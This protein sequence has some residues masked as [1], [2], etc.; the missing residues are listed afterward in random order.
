MLCVAE[1]DD[2]LCSAQSSAGH[3]SKHTLHPP[4]QTA[5]QNQNTLYVCVSGQ[6]LQMKNE[7]VTWP[8]STQTWGLIACGNRLRDFYYY[9]FFN[10]QN[11]SGAATL[12]EPDG[13]QPAFQSTWMAA[14]HQKKQR[15]G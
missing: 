7:M 5:R 4:H 14:E 3:E 12:C 6:P 15:R 13:E 1:A 11:F 8:H 2:D 9:F 10:F